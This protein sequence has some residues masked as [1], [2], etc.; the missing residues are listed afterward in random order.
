MAV[1]EALGEVLF[2]G[3]GEEGIHLECPEAEHSRQVLSLDPADA[4]FLK[5]VFYHSAR[6]RARGTYRHF[7]G[8]KALSRDEKRSRGEKY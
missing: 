5:L 2:V 7:A 3:R 4:G 8:R 6:G 1:P